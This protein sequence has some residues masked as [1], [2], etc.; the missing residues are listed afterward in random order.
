MWLVF[1]EVVKQGDARCSAASLRRRTSAAGARGKSAWQEREDPFVS[2]HR[3]D[4]AASSVA[5]Y[6]GLRSEL[7]VQAFSFPTSPDAPAT[8]WDP[9]PAG[10]PQ[11]SLDCGECSRPDG[12]DSDN[13][14]WSSRGREGD[15]T[16]EVSP[17]P[18]PVMYFSL[19]CAMYRCCYR[20]GPKC[21]SPAGMRRKH[22]RRSMNLRV[23]R[24]RTLFSFSS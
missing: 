7:F 12:E 15:R 9:Q 11:G 10:S 2:R 24:K 1:K 18:A 4:R 20:R 6:V 17:P 21:I 13:H 14:W 16:S 3:Y 22:I 8:Y 23:T 19:I 5:T